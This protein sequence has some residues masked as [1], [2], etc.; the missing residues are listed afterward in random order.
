MLDVGG[1]ISLALFV[2]AVVGAV[3]TNRLLRDAINYRARARRILNA[4]ERALA[5]QKVGLVDEALITLQRA[6]LECAMDDIC[7]QA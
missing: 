5:L 1:W 7:D 3:V 2:G 4:Y 6:E